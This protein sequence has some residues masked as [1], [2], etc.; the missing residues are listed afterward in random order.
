[1]AIAASESISHQDRSKRPRASSAILPQPAH[2]TSSLDV[3]IRQVEGAD[4][5]VRV[6]SGSQQQSSLIAQLIAPEI[7]NLK[8]DVFT[9]RC[10]GT[11][12][13]AGQTFNTQLLIRARTNVRTHP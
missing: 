3:I 12:G 4:A 6:E 5:L 10:A 2:I 1:M 8:L 11:N 13:A 9:C 7:E